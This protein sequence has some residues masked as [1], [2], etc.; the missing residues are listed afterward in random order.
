MRL[1]FRTSNRNN[2]SVLHRVY[3]SRVLGWKIRFWE[4]FGRMISCCL[5]KNEYKNPESLQNDLYSFSVSRCNRTI[6]DFDYSSQRV[7]VD[8]WVFEKVFF[9]YSIAKCPRF[10]LLLISENSKYTMHC[11][12]LSHCVWNTCSIFILR[13]A[14]TSVQLGMPKFPLIPYLYHSPTHSGFGAHALINRN[15]VL[16]FRNAWIRRSGGTVERIYRVSGP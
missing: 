5:F 15:R 3:N 8:R 10:S 1:L 11:V 9:F 6:D 12:E 7:N 14:T 2:T 16:L 13:Y 4:E